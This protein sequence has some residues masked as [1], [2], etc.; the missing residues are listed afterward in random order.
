MALS[1]PPCNTVACLPQTFH[2]IRIKCGIGAHNRHLFHHSLG[3][4][5]PIKRI[6]IMQGQCRY[7]DKIGT[8]IDKTSMSLDVGC[9]VMSTSVGIATVNLPDTP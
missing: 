2:R 1:L 3:N 7:C 4:D 6:T 8:V 9:Y 5:Q